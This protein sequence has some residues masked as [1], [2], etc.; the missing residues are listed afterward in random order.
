[1]KART[2]VKNNNYGDMIEEG[3][4]DLNSKLTEAKKVHGKTFSEG[5][6][7]KLDINDAMKS[8]SHTKKY[9]K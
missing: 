3:D 1:M 6:R 9:L 8:P 2:E 5:K 7:V 4:D